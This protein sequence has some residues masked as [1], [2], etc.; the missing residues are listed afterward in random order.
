MQEK[1]REREREKRKSEGT[2]LNYNGQTVC[3]SGN[4]HAEGEILQNYIQRVT[5]MEVKVLSWWVEGWDLK[6]LMCQRARVE[7]P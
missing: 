2:V 3:R 1:A 4:T 7:K 5:Q 6:S